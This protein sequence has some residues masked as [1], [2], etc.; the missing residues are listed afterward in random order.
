MR[1]LYARLSLAVTAASIAVAC[2]STAPA[3]PQADALAKEFITE[4]NAATIYVYRS[5]FN[6]FDTDTILYLDGRV[7]GTTVPGTYFRLDTNAGR[8]FLH[9]TAIDLGEIALETRRGQIYFVA[10]DVVGNQ[11][12]FRLVPQTIA[13]ERLR[14]CCTLLESWAPWQRPVVLR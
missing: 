12:N 11:S 6:D 10:L 5:E 4:P 1:I 7:I 13:R 8:H 9:G 2:T 14:A 3:P